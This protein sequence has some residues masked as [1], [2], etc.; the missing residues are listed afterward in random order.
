MARLDRRRARS[1]ASRPSP[2][3]AARCGPSCCTTPASSSSGRSTGATRTSEAFAAAARPALV[4]RIFGVLEDRRI[5]VATR[6]RYPGARRDLD[7]RARRRTRGGARRRRPS[8]GAPRSL[9]SLQ[10]HSLGASPRRAAR[11]G[12]C[13]G[14]RAACSAR[15]STSSDRCAPS[16]TAPAPRSP[17]A[18]CST[19][20]ST[21]RATRRTPSRSRSTS[22][23]RAR[24]TRPTTGREPT[25]TS[26]ARRPSDMRQEETDR[27]QLGRLADVDALD[28]EL[29]GRGGGPG[30][31]AR[32]ADRP[33]LPADAT[34]TT[35]R[36]SSSTTSGTTSPGATC[37]RGA[38]SSSAAWRATTGRSSATCAGATAC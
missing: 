3:I 34:T 20:T 27:A 36:G 1:C 32:Q 2:R 33:R 15:C 5:D 18:S 8:S 21:S 30:P 9:E 25:P 7:R 12:C 23:R 16:T 28:P 31:P 17:S 22:T 10:L 14:L 4:R 13:P 38:G 37:R 19:R 29:A 24:S 6:A 11:R 35:T 26:R